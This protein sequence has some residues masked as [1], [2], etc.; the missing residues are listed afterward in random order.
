MEQN[1]RVCYEDEIGDF[2]WVECS[3]PNCEMSF[4]FFEYKLYGG[5][6]EC[7]NTEYIK[8]TEPD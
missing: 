8:I 6:T 7:G 2:D 1:V 3:N 4:Q 5:C